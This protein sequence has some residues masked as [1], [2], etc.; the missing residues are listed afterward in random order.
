MT[1]KNL[2]RTYQGREDGDYRGRT[3]ATILVYQR[4]ALAIATE[5]GAVRK[6]PSDFLMPEGNVQSLL[7]RMEDA[8]KADKVQVFRERVPVTAADAA[9]LS[10]G[11]EFDFGEGVGKLPIT[12]FSTPF[13]PKGASHH[14]ERL[15]DFAGKETVYVYNAHAP[16]PPRPQLTEEEKAEKRAE[17]NAKRRE[18]RQAEKD[19]M[20]PEEKAAKEAE[21]AEALKKRDMTRIP[22]LAGSLAPDADTITV[23]GESAK[24]LGTGQEWVLKDQEAVDKLADRFP[25]AEFT[26][27]DRVQ[28]ANFEAPEP[29]PEP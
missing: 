22:V 9:G 27:G 19:A 18:A 20:T 15:G 10:V 4:G 7:Q 29:S 21:L 23:R 28:F 12:G 11:D 24:L 17:S 1:Q 25:D 16:K 13:S 3:F 26:V 6:S 14:D 8:A 5:A 2:I